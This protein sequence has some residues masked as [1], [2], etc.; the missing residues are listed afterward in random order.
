MELNKYEKSNYTFSFHGNAKLLWS[1]VNDERNARVD[2]DI[3]KDVNSDG[4]YDVIISD[5]EGNLLMLS[6]SDG[7]TIWSKNYDDAWV[8]IDDLDDDANGDGIMDVLVYWC[9]EEDYDEEKTYLTVKMLNGVNG[10]EFWEKTIL[11]EGRWWRNYARETDEDISGDGI[12]DVFVHSNGWDSENDRA[13][14]EMRA[15]N[16]KTGTELWEKEFPGYSI[17]GYLYRAYGD[18]NGD[19]MNDFV[20]YGNNWQDNLCGV[21]AIRGYDGLVLKIRLA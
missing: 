18:L 16:G 19:G 8:G 12:E 11:Y 6:G 15:L 21:W 3:I 20:I 1:Y 5:N 13:I 10:G 7:S 17:S 2:Y 9:R 4:I 14:S